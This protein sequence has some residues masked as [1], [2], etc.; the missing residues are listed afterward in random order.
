MAKLAHHVDLKVAAEVVPFLIKQTSKNANSEDDGLAIK[1]RI[2][3]EI[4]TRVARMLFEHPSCHT[5]S[6]VINGENNNQHIDVIA[7]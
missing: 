6:V 7:D 5:L 1:R 2:D 3:G 4:T